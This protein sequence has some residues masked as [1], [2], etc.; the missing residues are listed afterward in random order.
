MEQTHT[1]PEEKKVAKRIKAKLLRVLRNAD[2]VQITNSNNIHDQMHSLLFIRQAHLTAITTKTI[3]HD[4]L[5]VNK[6]FEL[7]YPFFS[8]FSLEPRLRIS[9]LLQFTSFSFLWAKRKKE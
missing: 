6:Q 3:A 5:A 7:F 1:H 8:V 9:C 2:S 4:A